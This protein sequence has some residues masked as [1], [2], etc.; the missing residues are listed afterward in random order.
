MWMLWIILSLAVH[1]VAWE[2]LPAANREEQAP[3]AVDP[4]AFAGPLVVE[5]E[6]SEATSPGEVV[7]DVYESLD[8]S[9]QWSLQPVEGAERFAFDAATGALGLAGDRPF[10]FEEQSEFE[11]HLT[12]GREGTCSPAESLFADDLQ[13]SGL[14][15]ASTADALGR[16]CVAV[17][18][19][20]ILDV[21][22]P[23]VWPALSADG[24]RFDIA[25]R[26]TEHVLQAVDPDFGDAVQY[27]LL[28]G[29][30]T[31][32]LTC[33]AASGRLSL[34][35][36]VTDANLH[37]AQ[38][39][40]LLAHLRVT[41]GSGLSS[42]AWT[43]VRIVDSRAWKLPPQEV[44]STAVTVPVAGSAGIAEQVVAADDDNERLDLPTSDEARLGAISFLAEAP[45]APLRLPRKETKHSVQ[46]PSPEAVV[47]DDAAE[48]TPSGS[49]WV[50]RLLVVLASIAIAVFGYAVWR[51]RQEADTSGPASIDSLNMDDLH[52]GDA[53]LPESVLHTLALATSPARSLRAEMSELLA[54]SRHFSLAEQAQVERRFH[55]KQFKV[56]AIA[57]LSAAGIAFGQSL[58]GLEHAF[59]QDNWV[60]I[61]CLCVAAAAALKAWFAFRQAH[62][63]MQRPIPVSRPAAVSAPAAG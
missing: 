41:D 28:P 33:D 23:P 11:L 57:T 48:P 44:A 19:V 31:A 54:V 35:A 60:F 52:Y 59:D 42:D 26:L 10:D 21:A 30:A 62:G 55:G 29:D 3:A 15:V 40:P 14:D 1:T 2:A 12:G 43:T 32:W 51:R 38:S 6:V 4:P 45:G 17:L 27:E 49:A 24:L 50:V 63:R 37:G 61:A 53:V 8:P 56:A 39:L 9:W 5:I 7:A 13:R 25:D 20:Q 18:R 22:E 34:A 46:A 36:D 58:F 47:A 16:R